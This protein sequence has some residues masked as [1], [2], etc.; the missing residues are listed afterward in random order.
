MKTTARKELVLL[1]SKRNCTPGS[2]AAWLKARLWIHAHHHIQMTLPSTGLSFEHLQQ[3][4]KQMTLGNLGA[5]FQ[6][7]YNSQ[8]GLRY[9]TSEGTSPKVF[10]GIR[11]DFSRL[12]RRLLSKSIGLV[13]GGGGARG[14]AHLGALRAL[15][16]A[17]IP[18][19]MVGGTSI[20]AF[21]GGLYARENDRV[22]VFGRV[23]SFATEVSSTWRTLLDLTYPFISMTS[24]NEFNRAIWK[25]FGDTQIEDCW[26]PYYCVTT[27]ITFSREEIHTSGYI[28]RYIR[29]S[30]SLAG[31]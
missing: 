13:L 21:V 10:T 29:A 24:G 26:L 11:S 8:L 16:E 22:S 20:G 14:I 3:K 15:E 12:S 5:H 27:N 7:I 2:T 23:K 30:M 25:S 28:W 4:H 18:I 19:D 17:G 6:K 9:P 1:N 31:W